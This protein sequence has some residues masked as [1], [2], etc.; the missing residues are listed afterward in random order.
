MLLL[1]LLPLLLPHTCIC[2]LLPTTHTFRLKPTLSL[3]PTRRHST[4]NNSTDASRRSR[5]APGRR[6]TMI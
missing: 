1:L 5:H 4:A 6:V 3:R 2:I